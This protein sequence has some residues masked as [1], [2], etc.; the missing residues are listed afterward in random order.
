MTQTLWMVQRMF[1]A[2]WLSVLMLVIG[3]WHV[4]S[5]AHAQFI[6]P[7]GSSV[8]IG[9]TNPTSDLAFGGDTARKIQLEARTTNA[10]GS[11]L[12]VVGGAGGTGAT[13]VTGGALN[14]NGG[15]AAGTSGAAVGGNVVINGGAGVNSGDS[16][17]VILADSSNKVGIGATS[18]GAKLHIKTSGFPLTLQKASVFTGS[19]YQAFQDSTGSDIA[20]VGFTASSNDN[21]AVHNILNG[22]LTFTTNNSTAMTIKSDGKVGMGTT[23]PGAKLQVSGGDLAVTTQSNGVILRATDGANCFRLTVNNAGTLSTSSVTCP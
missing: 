22:D 13:G 3:L 17:N 21:F 5:L 2:S 16:G 19:F 4:P 14:L 10:A 12:T 7:Q 23:S 20:Y 8:G 6:V 1:G 11:A 15:A 18:P 9:T